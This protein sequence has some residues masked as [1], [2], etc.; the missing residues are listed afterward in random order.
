MNGGEDATGREGSGAKNAMA[1]LAG[2]VTRAAG[3][4]R[5]IPAGDEAAAYG[6]LR[7]LDTALAGLADLLRSVPRIAELG[8]PAPAVKERL[9]RS[10][11]ELAAKGAD[12][13]TLRSELD[14]LAETEKHLDEIT[15]QGRQLHDRVAELE[16]A[17]RTAAEIPGLR[18]RVQALE[19]E[20]AAL[21]AGDGPEVCARLAAAVGQLATLTE[22]QRAMMGDAA[23]SIADRAEA[24]ARELAELHARRDTAAADVERLESEAAQLMAEHADTLPMLTAWSQADLDLAEGVC[25]AM[26]TTG[27]TVLESLH[28]ELSGIT[29]RLTELDEVLGPLLAKHARAYEEARRV[30]PY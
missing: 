10:R 29:Q 2:A 14:G 9:K 5:A 3:A 8:D 23:A 24:A 20:V 15:T 28:A 11:A 12:L 27:G 7:D 21:D 1:E 17:Q 30:R 22:A 18:A 25:T 4:L 19:L 13:A 6:C 16:Q 26:L